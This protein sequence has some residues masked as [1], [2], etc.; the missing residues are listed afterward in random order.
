MA[1]A[2]QSRFSEVSGPPHE[3]WTATVRADQEDRA[4]A[5]ERSN[6]AAVFSGIFQRCG[7]KRSGAFDLPGEGGRATPPWGSGANCRPSWAILVEIVF[8]ERG[9]SW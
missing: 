5:M 8:I 7:K 4:R 3:F 6:F 9:R 1:P 2:N